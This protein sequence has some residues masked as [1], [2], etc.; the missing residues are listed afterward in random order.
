M[1]AEPFQHLA[2][3]RARGH[4]PFRQPAQE[5]RAPLARQPLLLEDAALV[6]AV[7]RGEDDPR[8]DSVK[9]RRQVRHADEAAEQ[10]AAV[11][12]AR[13]RLDPWTDRRAP[14]FLKRLSARCAGLRSTAVIAAAFAVR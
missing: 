1:S 13:G 8:I 11:E 3:P 9:P 2:Q 5:R 14:S 4:M 6:G 12:A 10:P 7:A